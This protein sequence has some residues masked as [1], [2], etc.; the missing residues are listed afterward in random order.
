MGITLIALGIIGLSICGI[1]LLRLTYV[2]VFLS[3]LGV[4]GFYVHPVESPLLSTVLL[5]LGVL[6]L[7]T[8]KMVQSK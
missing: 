7:R 1:V 5:I 8:R 4:A 2:L 3:P 6:L